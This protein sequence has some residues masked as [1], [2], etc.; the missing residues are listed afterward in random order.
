MPPIVHDLRQDRQVRPDQNAHA[1]SLRGRGRVIRRRLATQRLSSA[2]LR[3]ATEVVRVLGCVQSQDHAM[4]AWALGMRVR[5]ATYDG[6]LAEQRSGAFVRTHLLRPTWHFVAAEDLR[7]MLAVTSPKVLAGMAT[8][9]RQLGLDG[10]TVSRGLDA[11]TTVL[12]GDPLTRKQI[13]ALGHARLPAAGEALGHLLLVAELHGLVCS[14]PPRG[15]EHTY[16]LLDEVVPPAAELDRD[17]AVR[18][19][20]A[21]FF[22]GHG[23][24]SERDLARWCGFT[25]AEIRAATDDLRAA[26]RLDVLTVNDEDLF[27]EPARPPR[28]VAAEPAARLLWVYDEAVLTYPRTGFRRAGGAGSMDRPDVMR[29]VAGGVVTVDDRDVGT[30]NRRLARDAVEVTVRL[31]DRLSAAERTAVESAAGRYADFVARP[32]DLRLS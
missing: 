3:S 28:V 19:L 20:T 30:W 18:R 5:G 8:R 21:R 14:G 32:L 9:H 1:E 25:L 4:G 24:A 7:W 2:P 13:G 31:D 29:M 16:A 6:V 22:A 27:F 10:P 12:A 11:L 17:E 15:S 26:G 23:P